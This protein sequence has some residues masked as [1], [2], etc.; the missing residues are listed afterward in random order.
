MIKL[1]N[2]ITKTGHIL[3]KDA[4]L[5]YIE[6]KLEFSLNDLVE[7]QMLLCGESL[8]RKLK[9]KNNSDLY[10]TLAKNDRGAFHLTVE[11]TS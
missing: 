4:S 10:Q 9:I 7:A 11:R 3:I 8:S 6:T 2:V 1:Y 5:N